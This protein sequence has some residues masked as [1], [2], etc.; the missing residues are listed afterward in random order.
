[1]ELFT[2]QIFSEFFPAGKVLSGSVVKVLCNK[3]KL[4]FPL[5]HNTLNSCRPPE[6]PRMFHSSWAHFEAIALFNAQIIARND[7]VVVF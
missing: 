3:M 4:L 6:L 5:L 2:M 1:M 7:A